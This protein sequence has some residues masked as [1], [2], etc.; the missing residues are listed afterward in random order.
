MG[1]AKPSTKSPCKKWTRGWR[2][3]LRFSRVWVPA[4]HRLIRYGQGILKRTGGWSSGP[5]RTSGQRAGER[6]A[7]EHRA[8]DFEGG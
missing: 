6:G 2:S 1:R 3:G 8:E 5:A 4:R 7:N